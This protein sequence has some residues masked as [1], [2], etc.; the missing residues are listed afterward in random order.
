MRDSTA[1]KVASEIP[2]P[3]PHGG[4]AARVATALGIEPD[5]VLDVSVSLNPVAPDFK[6][7]FERNL[8]SL[9]RYPDDAFATSALADAIG[10][11]ASRVVL[12]NGGSEAIALVATELGRGWVEEPDFSLY[13]RYLPELDPR[14]GRFASNPRNPTG[15]LATNEERALVWDEAFYQIA[16][17]RWTRG[18]CESGSWVVGSLTKLFACPG[19]RV[20][21]VLAPDHQ[22]AQQIRM[23]RPEWS[24]NSLACAVLPEMLAA[25]DLV[26]ISRKVAV[27]RE[28]TSSLLTSH[29][30]RVEPSDANFMVVTGCDDL[31][32]RLARQAVVVRDLSSFGM[33][34][35]FRIAVC[36]EREL[37]RLDAA[38]CLALD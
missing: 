6:R 5:E 10:V 17:G 36:A 33:P 25:I 1:A 12:T 29:G 24:A 34:S 19:L 2:P 14:A 35:S 4:D 30:L 31:R 22:Q 37:Q 13:R 23:R 11:D 8:D 7:L 38:L 16:T 21:Y 27:L 32:E 15:R 18:D 28:Q 26:D 9:S 3:G 20:G